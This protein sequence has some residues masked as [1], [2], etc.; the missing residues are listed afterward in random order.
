VDGVLKGEIDTYLAPGQAQAAAYSISGLPAGDHTLKVEAT[1]RRRS[2]SGGA[3][4][5][6]DAFTVTNAPAPVVTRVEQNGSGLT[7]G[8]TWTPNGLSLHSQSSAILS[9]TAGSRATFAFEGTG[10]TWRAFRDTWS[11]IA[12]VYLDGVLQGTVDT[13]SANDKA[14][15]AMYS[16]GGLTQGTHT[17]VIEVTGTKSAYSRGAWIWIDGF[18]VTSGGSTPS[19]PTAGSYRAEQTSAAVKWTGTWSPNNGAFN[20]GGSARISMEAGSRATFT[21]TGNAASW[22]AYRDEWSGIAK[23]Y[24]DGVLQ[25]EI[26][27]YA[28]PSKSGVAYAVS[29]LTWGEHTIT[30]EAAGRRNPSSRGAWIWVDAF[31]YVGAGM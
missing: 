22:I 26:D 2:A 20:S 13:Y 14:Q 28:S 30:I 1:G 31:D 4:V 19:T 11:G 6:I 29:G 16:V 25:D 24:I 5:W 15:A 27:T 17:L 9:M 18:D 12:R 10:V 7:Y 21:F 23:V 8:G 3:W